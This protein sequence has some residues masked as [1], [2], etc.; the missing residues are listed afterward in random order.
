MNIRYI[1]LSRFSFREK[2][3]EHWSHFQLTIFLCTSEICLSR[4]PFCEKLMQQWSHFQLTIFSCI[5][6]ICLSSFS[7]REN[8]IE[9]CGHGIAVVSWTSPTWRYSTYRVVKC[10]SH[11][12]HLN[13]TFLFGNS[14][15]LV[16]LWYL[17]F[18]CSFAAFLFCF[19]HSAVFFFW[20]DFACSSN[21]FNSFAEY[22]LMQP[23]VSLVLARW[24]LT[25]PWNSH[26]LQWVSERTASQFVVWALSDDEVPA[27]GLSPSENSRSSILLG[28]TRPQQHS[29]DS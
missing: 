5:S 9:H 1:C 29:L 7:F 4:F 21:H 26:P 8:L 3:R 17:L 16:F 13:S 10:L 15:V 27:C 23:L 6:E 12:L 19:F 14:L 18:S 22:N 2:L 20:F 11:M 25:L 24:I 28:G